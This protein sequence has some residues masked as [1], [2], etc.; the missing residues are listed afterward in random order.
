MLLFLLLYELRVNSFEG[1][2]H[3][4]QLVLV[5]AIVSTVRGIV[6]YITLIQK[7]MREV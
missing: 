5:V 2:R 1:T 6:Y 7:N 4:L 3:T